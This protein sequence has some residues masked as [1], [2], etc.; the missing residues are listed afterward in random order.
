MPTKPEPF[1]III[2]SIIKTKVL[3]TAKIV[4]SNN[5][6]HNKP[7]VILITHKKITLCICVCIT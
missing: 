2:I 1:T 6:N 5:N 3:K 4:T 7:M